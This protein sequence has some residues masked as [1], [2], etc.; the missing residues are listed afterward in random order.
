MAELMHHEVRIHNEPVRHYVWTRTHQGD[1]YTITDPAGVILVSEF[2][3]SYREPID[4]ANW[5][6]YWMHQQSKAAKP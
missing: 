4:F 2:Q 6:T 1:Q 3:D 5:F